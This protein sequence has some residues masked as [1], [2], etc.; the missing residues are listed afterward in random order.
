MLA[1]TISIIIL[2]I[3]AVIAL[4]ISYAMFWPAP[5]EHKNKRPPD[6]PKDIS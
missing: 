4:G 5:V 1:D 6:P 2:S 3:L